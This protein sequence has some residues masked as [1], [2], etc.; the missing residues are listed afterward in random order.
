MSREEIGEILFHPGFKG[1]FTQ[2]VLWLE[3]HTE[4]FRYTF[5]RDFPL[6]VLARKILEWLK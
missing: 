6:C 1:S 4:D 5:L 2:A 3:I